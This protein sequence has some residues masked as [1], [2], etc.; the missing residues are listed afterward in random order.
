MFLGTHINSSFV[1]GAANVSFMR[2]NNF[3]SEESKISLP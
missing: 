1:I 3:E 2:V